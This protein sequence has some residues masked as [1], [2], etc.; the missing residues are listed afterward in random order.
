MYRRGLRQVGSG[1]IIRRI[2][3]VILGLI[4]VRF[5][6]EEKDKKVIGQW[7]TQ[8][9]KSISV[10]CFIMQQFQALFRSFFFRSQ[11]SLVQVI[12]IIRK[13][14][15]LSKTR[16]ITQ[17]VVLGSSKGSGRQSGDVLYLRSFSSGVEVRVSVS[18]VYSRMAVF[19]LEKGVFFLN[20][21]EYFIEN[22][23]F[24]VVR[25]S[26]KID[27]FEVKTDKNSTIW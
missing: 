25:V 8:L 24:R 14:K 3:L 15:E 4:K 23:R 6:K 16:V 12:V 11:Q 5:S 21:V 26:R 18:M 27:D 10:T 22:L 1:T 13:Q 19:R 9:V 2:N 20:F 17:F 7:R